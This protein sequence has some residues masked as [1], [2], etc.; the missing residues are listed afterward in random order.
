MADATYMEVKRTDL[1]ELSSPEVK[2][3]FDDLFRFAK[4]QGALNNNVRPHY[5]QRFAS[6]P[7]GTR[8]VIDTL[9]A[10]SLFSKVGTAACHVDVQEMPGYP[11]VSPESGTDYPQ[12]WVG[13]S[14]QD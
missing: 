7:F 5:E 11:K 10:G 2:K 9:I 14:S 13:R 3:E 1:M 4:K 8:Q 12:S 6:D